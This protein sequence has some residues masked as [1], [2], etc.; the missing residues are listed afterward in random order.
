MVTRASSGYVVEI[1]DEVLVFDHGQGSHSNFLKA[2]FRAVDVHN[3]FFSHLHFDH[4]ADYPRLVHTRWDQGA[5]QIPELTVYAPKYMHR[6]SELLFQEN[7]VFH[8]DLDGRMNSSGSRVVYKNR[9]GILPRLRPSPQ[10]TS[11]YDGQVIETKNCKVTVREVCHQ[12]GYIEPYAF[13]IESDEGIL[14]Y[15]GDTGPCR[16]IEEIAEGADLLIHMCYFV[17]GTFNQD[18]KTLT[19]SGHLEAARTASKAGVKTLLTTHFTPQ[20]DALGVKEKCLVEMTKIFD[21][22]IIWGEDLMV[23]PIKPT[24]VPDAG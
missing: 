2:G 16:G 4:C 7:G 10:I 11:I 17:S 15:S 1:G 23:I 5:G 19:S 14:V 18:D 24:F 9:G 20:M 22:T 6:M 21:G 3:V 8:P 13:R 12:P